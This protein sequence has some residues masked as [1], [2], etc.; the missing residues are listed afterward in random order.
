MRNSCQITFEGLNVNRTL[1][2][3]NKMGIALYGVTREG[4]ITTIQV[5]ARRAKQTIALLQ[6]K[7]YNIIGI[8][9]FGLTAAVKFVKFRFVLPIVCLLAVI[10]LAISSQFC[11]K[12][13]VSGDF[14]S[15]LVCDALSSAGVKVG[16]N[17]SKLNVDVLENT[18]ANEM[19]AMYAVVTRSGSVLYV[20]VVAKKEIAPPID[21]TVRRDIVATRSG[22]VTQLLCEQGNALVKVGDV[23]KAGDVLIEGKRLYNDNTYDE[24]YAMGRVTLQI[25]ATG[26]A[27]YT[28]YKSA[29][30]ETGK[31][32][33]NTGVVLF[34]KEYAKACPFNSYTVTTSVTRL[35][36]LNLE[37]RRNIYRE[38]KT[39]QVEATFK[40]CLEE[41]K[42]KAYQ[43]A[44]E[45]CDFAVTDTQYTESDSGVIVTLYGE[46]HLE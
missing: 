15:N 41:L 21:M 32:F 27:E 23:V 43:A 6:E 36:P 26:Y 25:T 17:M 8:K 7:C 13:V 3:L 14:D 2:Q 46:I 44:K 24:V 11:F 12:I 28:G 42:T 34:G 9:Y 37:I 30:V 29:I 16:S 22:V 38:T 45:V 18:L 39:V 1:A 10:V 31:V 33:K 19:G 35:A 4:K 40:E 5:P 20:N